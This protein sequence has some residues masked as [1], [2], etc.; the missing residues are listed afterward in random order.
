MVARQGFR[1]TLPR[2]RWQ[3]MLLESWK[4]VGICRSCT[5]FEGNGRGQ[6]TRH[7][8]QDAGTRPFAPRLRQNEQGAAALP[9]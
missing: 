2:T 4:R 1:A 8:R 5:M 3:T 9:A 7:T 6:A